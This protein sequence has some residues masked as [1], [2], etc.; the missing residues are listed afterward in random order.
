VSVPSSALTRLIAAVVALALLDAFVPRALERAERARYE[1]PVV[2]RFAYSDLF[3]IG[4]VTEYLREHP[5]GDRPRAVFLGNSVVWGYRL[6]EQDSLPVQFQRRNPSTRVLNLAIN[7]FGIGSAAL[8]L[9]DVIDSVDLVVFQAYGREVDH[10]LAA[11]IPVSDDDVARYRLDPPDRVEQRFEGA[12][13]AWRLYGLSYRLQMAWLGTSTRYYV[14]Q[15]KSSLMG[16]APADDYAPNPRAAAGPRLL[17]AVADADV[18]AA[19]LRE[20]A[21]ADPMLWEAASLVRAHGKRAIFWTIDN[22]AVGSSIDW[23]DLNRAFLGA[24]TFATI[25]LPPEMMMDELHMTANGSAATADVLSGLAGDL[26][27]RGRGLH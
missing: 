14:Y 15:H 16:R 13:G 7:R 20:L 6:P 4:P 9:K 17:H 24:C 21:A 23:A 10:G 8:W 12:L 1:G 2:F 25:A 19:R 5:R 26:N 11:I 27:A 22:A 3:G 18:P